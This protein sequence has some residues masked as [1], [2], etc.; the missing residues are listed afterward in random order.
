MLVVSKRGRKGQAD[1]TSASALVAV[2]ATLIV[3][4]LLFLPPDIREDLL[5]GN[6]TN[7]SENTS[8]SNNL[9]L[10][11]ESPQHISYVSQTEYEHS[12]PV[13]SLFKT[14]NA[15]NLLT[16]NPFYIKNSWT[17]RSIKDISFSVPDLPNTDNVVLSFVAAKH[18]GI[19]TVTL[20]GVVVF[21]DSVSSYNV[22]PIKLDRR[23]LQNSN[24]LGF[25]VNG[26]GAAFWATNEYMIQNLQ[27]NGEATD[28][29]RQA[30]RTVI[31][32][33]TVE[34]FNLESAMLKFYPDCIE[35]NVGV[36]DIAI[37]NFNIYS[38]VPDC[39]TLNRINIPTG[40]LD[41]G[42]NTVSFK[43]NKGSYLVDQA[44]I[45][46]Y[47]KDSPL[48]IY[49]FDVS[50]T[51]NKWIQNNTYNAVLTVNLVKTN[52]EKEA[53]FIINGHTTTMRTDKDTYAKSLPKEWFFE[54]SNYLRIVPR[55]QLDISVLKI[56]LKK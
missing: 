30:S 32:L 20:N 28:L 3:I 40:L 16:E 25:S 50:S 1:A 27:V 46:T 4:Y 19:L 26:V 18:S 5:V 39:R 37:N 7:E 23:I 49:Y 15:V 10:L 13:F 55:D 42:D 52:E 45:V 24:I 29:S 36:L 43:T 53:E 11:S 33:K 21:Q 2:I 41:A 35:A 56:E 14:T 38:G 47:L 34:K 12:I 8:A 48:V 31:N 51:Q 44:K 54:G 6:K 22:A 17:G 9:T